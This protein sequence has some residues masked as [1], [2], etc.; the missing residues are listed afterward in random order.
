MQRR[1]QTSVSQSYHEG[2]LLLDGLEASV[3]KL[4][5]RV[6]EFEVDLLLSATVGLNQQRLEAQTDGSEQE[7]K[8]DLKGHPKTSSDLAQGQNP[9]LG[10]HDASLQHDEVVG[11]LSV[12]DETA[13]TE[14]GR[15]RLEGCSSA[16]AL[17]EGAPLTRG[18]MLLL[19]R[20]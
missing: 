16:S 4:G 8:Q 12:V 7:P 19:E 9:L 2:L 14:P 10:P 13:L 20:S 15:G 5:G 6:D 18:L 3:T 17:G 11:H 1:G